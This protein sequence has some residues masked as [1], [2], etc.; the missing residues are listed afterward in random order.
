MRNQAVIDAVKHAAKN[1]VAWPGCYPLVVI[2]SDGEVL[3]CDCAR[4]EFAR[5]GRATRD[6]SFCG[7][8]ADC[9]AIHWEGEPEICANCNAEIESAYGVPDD[10]H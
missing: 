9:V 1:K 10:E 6:N 3:C 5:I 7:W 2:M 4:S 8:R